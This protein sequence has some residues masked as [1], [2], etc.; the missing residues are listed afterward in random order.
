MPTSMPVNVLLR[1]VVTMTVLSTNA[2]I[3]VKYFLCANDKFLS[4][5]IAYENGTTTIYL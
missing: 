3:S 2:E 4:P 5:V 1:V